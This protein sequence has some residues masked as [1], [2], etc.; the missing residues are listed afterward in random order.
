MSVNE[1]KVSS[2]SVPLLPAYKTQGYGFHLTTV[3]RPKRVQSLVP[4]WL[5]VFSSSRPQVRVGNRGHK[6]RDVQWE[7]NQI[8]Q[9]VQGLVL[10]YLKMSTTKREDALTLFV[11]GHPLRFP[12]YL[13]YL[14]VQID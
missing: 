12:F 3:C 4:S 1:R 9:C 2:C 13:S 10:L 11:E 7:S 14:N 6:L 5:A 8:C